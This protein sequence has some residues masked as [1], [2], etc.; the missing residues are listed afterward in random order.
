MGFYSDMTSINNY[1]KVNGNWL[2]NIVSELHGKEIDVRRLILQNQLKNAAISFQKQKFSSG[3]INGI[4][5]IVSNRG[6][7]N[8]TIVVSA[9]YDGPGAY[10]N[11]SGVAVVLG[12]M[13]K[14]RNQRFLNSVSFVLFDQEEVNQA[15]SRTYLD[16]S[17]PSME[18]CLNINIDG[19]GIG[20]CCLGLLNQRE[21][22]FLIDKELVK[23]ALQVDATTFVKRK[24]S[25][26]H[27][28]CLPYRE[29]KE[30]IALKKFP[31]T[32]QTLH[33]DSD[34]PE[35]L[36]TRSLFLNFKRFDNLLHRISN[37]NTL[38]FE[39]RYHRTG[40]IEI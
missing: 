16:K 1:S 31:T 32:W 5:F 7:T 9:H 26:I 40:I 36:S 24:I 17:D 27:C 25:A 33:T 23:V 18:I 21:V 37:L 6:R 10:D 14:Y 30:F 28:F 20:T 4:N 12:L 3:K 19:C 11:A 2:K 13:I 22:S 15:G 35:R 38:K 29:S 34:V 39:F 8:K